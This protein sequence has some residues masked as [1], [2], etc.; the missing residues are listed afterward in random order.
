MLPARRARAPLSRSLF[1]VSREFLR[2]GLRRPER[3]AKNISF[4]SI[5]SRNQLKVIVPPTSCSTA[6]NGW[7]VCR[8]GGKA[9]VIQHKAGQT[10]LHVWREAASRRKLRVCNRIAKRVVV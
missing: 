10:Q 2:V 7:A 5:K 4:E 9:N 3:G 6:R 1:V 8:Y